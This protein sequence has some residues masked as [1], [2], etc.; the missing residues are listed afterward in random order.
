MIHAN[1]HWKIVGHESLKWQVSVVTRLLN[2][3]FLRTCLIHVRH[4]IKVFLI[5]SEGVKD[6][7]LFLLPNLL[8]QGHLKD[9]TQKGLASQLSNV[10]VCMLALTEVSSS[11]LNGRICIVFLIKWGFGLRYLRH[12]PNP[13]KTSNV[14]RYVKNRQS[15]FLASW[16]SKLSLCQSCYGSTAIL[17]WINQLA[18]YWLL[19]CIHLLLNLRQ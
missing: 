17:Y 7:G 19:R 11:S 15:D 18:G 16:V 10:I 14:K 5:S 12:F 4:G 3:M 9:K 8:H 13:Y 2:W 1:R 6:S